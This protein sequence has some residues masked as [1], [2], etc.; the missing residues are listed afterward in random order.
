[1]GEEKRD[2]AR[3]GDDKLVMVCFIRMTHYTTWLINVVMVK[4]SNG[5]WRMFTDYTFLNK[6]WPKD[7]YHLPSIDCLIDGAVG[8]TILSFLDAYFGYNQ[9]RMH[10]RD[11]EKTAFMTDCNNFYYEVMPFDL[12]NAGATYQ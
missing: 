7:F 11:K 12:K 3:H 10:P 1:M 5:K 4:R 6:A 2:A 8:H 9:I